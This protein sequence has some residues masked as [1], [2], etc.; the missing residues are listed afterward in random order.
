VHKY[1]EDSQ[2]HFESTLYEIDTDIRNPVIK[3][4]FVFRFN[5]SSQIPQ[6]GSFITDEGVYIFC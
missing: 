5:F 1:F 6:H 4:K 2:P 3:S